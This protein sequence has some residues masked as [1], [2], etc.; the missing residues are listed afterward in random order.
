MSER[1][2]TRRRFV[3]IGATAAAVATVS[4][5]ALYAATWAP[6]PR[7]V[8]LTMGAGMSKVLVV[9]ATKSGCTTGVAE[10]I[11]ADFV[12]KDAVVDVVCAD[13]APQPDGYDAVIVGSGI[14]VGQWHEAAR[15]WVANHAEAL[16]QIPV[17]FFT[18]NLTQVTEPER[19]DEVRAWTDPITEST[20]IEPVDVATFPGWFEPKQFSLLERTILKAM[21]AP[22]GDFRDYAAVDQWT[23]KVAPSLGLTG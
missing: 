21:K 22:Q 3:R 14:R 9:Y 5:S 4:G 20:G 6:E 17:A 19:A 15:T 16:K 8:G 23:D 10:H 7:R 1:T 12:D 11:G 2:M 13:E 18:V